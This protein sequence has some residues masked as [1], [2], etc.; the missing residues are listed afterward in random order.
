MK[1]QGSLRVISSSHWDSVAAAAVVTFSQQS[2]CWYL[3]LNYV[4][5]CLKHT[6]LSFSL[7]DLFIP[8][9][10]YLKT[11]TDS[12]HRHTWHGATTT[13]WTCVVAKSRGK[14]DYL[15]INVHTLKHTNNWQL[16]K[17]CVGFYPRSRWNLKVSMCKNCTPIQ[18]IPQTNR[19]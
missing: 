5:N 6:W 7:C 19:S 8:F 4:P 12:K 9:G 3:R 16:L 14:G 13:L 2:F 18:S 10:F 15:C 1:P 17:T 11:W